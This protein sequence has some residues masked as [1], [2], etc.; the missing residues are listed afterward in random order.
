MTTRRWFKKNFKYGDLWTYHKKYRTPGRHGRRVVDPATLTDS[1]RLVN[2]VLDLKFRVVLDYDYDELAVTSSRTHEIVI[3][4]NYSKPMQEALF[5]HEMGHLTLFNSSQFT[6]LRETTLRSMIGKIIYSEGNVL[7]FDARLLAWVDNVVQDIVIETLSD[8][9]ICSTSLVEYHHNVGVK[10]L[11][12]LEEVKMITREVCGQYLTDD[13]A[14]F[15]EEMLPQVLEQLHNEEDKNQEDGWD[16]GDASPGNGDESNDPGSQNDDGDSNGDEG[17]DSDQNDSPGSSDA[18]APDDSPLR[19]LL[20]RMGAP[21]DNGDDS[22]PGSGSSADGDGS[23][24]GQ[25]HAG[26]KPTGSAHDNPNHDASNSPSGDAGASKHSGSDG[27]AAGSDKL[28]DEIS[29]IPMTAM[30]Q[31]LSSMLNDLDQDIDEIGREVD[32][33]RKTNRFLDEVNL[34]DERRVNRLSD[35]LDKIARREAKDGKT[36]PRL[37]GM[38]KR[39]NDEIKR[40][41]SD[42]RRDKRSRIAEEKRARKI[43]RLE[44]QLRNQKRLRKAF[45]LAG[46][47]PQPLAAGLP[48]D[49]D[50]GKRGDGDGSVQDATPSSVEKDDSAPM[51][52]PGEWHPDTG[53]DEPSGQARSYDP[54]IPL[55]IMISRDESDSS[56]MAGNWVKRIE[57]KNTPKRITIIDSDRQDVIGVGSK[58]AQ[59]EYTYFRSSRKE[60]SNADMMKGKRKLRATGVNVLIG[61]DVSGSMEQEWSEKAREIGLMVEDLRKR[62]DIQG[63]IFF[64]YNENLKK[65]SENY[66]ELDPHANGGNA[67]GYVYQQI[68][69]KLPIRTRNEII[70]VTD[71]GD[72]L[73]FNLEK[74]V[75]ATRN[76]VQVKNHISVVDTQPTGFYDRSGIDASDEWSL[77]SMGDL[78]LAGKIEGDIAGL[79]SLA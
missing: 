18:D 68:M 22:G 43:K 16:D 46:A 49:D 38:K 53:E 33:D 79:I 45:E 20:R 12:T 56:R 6:T 42:E 24:D 28:M 30:R 31:L 3:N 15:P 77:Y 19:D 55:P 40:L 51:E 41:T 21:Q 13:R 44:M 71:C 48:S 29:K 74:T 57:C 14:R 9:C 10:H 67:F 73:G 50:D 66:D 25:G 1:Y 5:Q 76:G 52:N 75:D 54:A 4:A 47:K 36:S 78:G 62:M 11:E 59:V 72:N 63:V 26:V 35:Q 58:T 17:E 2:A 37:E 8:K 61:L 69:Q 23:P 64:T 27:D 70:L 34:E 39:I 60:F 7:R 32:R 65:W